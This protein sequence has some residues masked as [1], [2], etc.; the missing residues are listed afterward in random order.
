MKEQNYTKKML[1]MLLPMA[2]SLTLPL[3]MLNAPV[4]LMTVVDLIILSPLLFWS[5]KLS[6]FIPY[7]YY[8]IKPI[9]YIWALVVTLL[10]A[11]DFLAIAFYILMGIQTP[12]MIMNFLGT[13][14]IVINN[15]NK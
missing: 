8:I 10:G 3:L 14:I 15:I 11:Q 7:A 9:L 4:W 5:L 6:V 2:L 13:V 12:K 1:M